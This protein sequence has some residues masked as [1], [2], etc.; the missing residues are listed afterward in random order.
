[1]SID[2]L[3]KNIANR[4]IVPANFAQM[5]L[6]SLIRTIWFILPKLLKFYYRF[7]LFLTTL[8]CF[9]LSPY[10]ALVAIGWKAMVS[11]LAILAIEISQ[12]S[13]GKSI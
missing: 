7:A 12:S 1:L 2:N 9:I 6:I 13:T 3:A 5:A 11:S 4:Q 8:D 10:W